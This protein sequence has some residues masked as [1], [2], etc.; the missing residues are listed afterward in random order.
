MTGALLHLVAN[1]GAAQN[2]WLDSDPQ[3]TFFKKIFRRHTPFATELVP[4]QFKTTLNFGGSTTTT[5]PFLGDLVYR[6]FFVC[7]IPKLAAMFINSKSQDMQQIINSTNFTDANF[8]KNLRKFAQGIDQVEFDRIFNLIDMTLENYGKE[9]LQCLNIINTM[10]TYKDPFG[11]TGI[12]DSMNNQNP[13]KSPLDTESYSGLT[14]NIINK[15]SSYDYTKFKMDL[16]DQ[17]MKYKKEYFLIYELLK[18]IYLSEKEIVENTPL[19]NPGRLVDDL[20]L[21]DIF[22]N[23]LPNKEIFFKYYMNNINSAYL[24]L[25]GFDPK[26]QDLNYLI[27]QNPIDVNASTN[28]YANILYDFGPDFHYMLNSYNIIINVLKSMAKTVPIVIAKAFFISE[29]GYNIYQNNNQTDI[30]SNF[31]FPTI[32]DPNYK[33][34]FMLNINTLEKPI[35]DNNFI[36]IDYISTFEQ[37]YPNKYT[38]AY[39]QLFNNQANI[40]F[41]NIRKFM[42][43]LFQ[44][45]QSKL[46]SST[47]KLFFNNSPPLSNIYG[48]IAPTNNFK[49]NESHRIKNVFNTN[50]WFFYFFKYLDYINEST[51]ATYVKNVVVPSISVNG[52]IFF[53]NM[54]LLLKINIEYYMN[55]I[56]YLLNDLYASSPSTNPNDSMKNYAPVVYHN[57]INNIDIHNNLLAITILFHRNHVPTILEMFQYIY[58]FLSIMDIFTI[59]TYLAVDMPEIEVAEIA[60]IRTIAKLLYYNIFKYFMDVYDRFS[61]EAPANFTMN[62]YDQNENESIKNY[63]MHF[64]NGSFILPSSYEQISLTKNVSQ[65]EF[66]F[67]SEMVN[68]REQQKFY[69]NTLFNKQYILE[70]VGQTSADLVGMIVNSFSD[71]DKN[72]VIDIGRIMDSADPV[73]NY[74]DIS[75]QHNIINGMPDKLYYATF[76]TKR[77]N[78]EAYINTPYVSRNYGLVPKP[79]NKLPLL[80]P[81]PLPPTDPYGIDP[82]YYEHNQAITDFISL[83]INN[84]NILQMNIPVYWITNNDNYT[85]N[86]QTNNKSFQMYN[87]DYFRIKHEIFYQNSMHIPITFIDEYQFHLLK[88]L[89]LTGHL[90]NIYPNYDKYLYHWIQT[91]IFYLIKHT[92]PAFDLSNML[93]LYLDYIEESIDKNHI[94]VPYDFIGQMY[95]I[96]EHMYIEF[97]KNSKIEILQQAKPFMTPNMVTNNKF[98]DNMLLNHQKFN[99]VEKVALLR[100]NFLAQ[101]F[102]YVKYQDS[103]N[104]INKI[105]CPQFITYDDNIAQYVY[106]ILVC[107]NRNGV[108]LS[109]LK[110]F[111]PIVYLYPDM[112]PD[113]ISAILDMLGKLDDFGQYIFGS[114]I[115]FFNPNSMAKLTIKDILDIINITFM[116]TK[117]IYDYSLMNNQLQ[118]IMEK[119]SKYQPLLLNKLSLSNEINTY[120]KNFSKNKYLN[121]DNIDY[122]SKLANN[123][124]INYNIYKNYLVEQIMPLYNNNQNGHNKILFYNLVDG[125]LDYF[126][127]YPNKNYPDKSLSVPTTFKKHIMDDMFDISHQIP[128]LE[129]YFKYIDNEYYAFIYFFMDYAKKNNLSSKDIKNPLIYICHNKKNMSG[130][131]SCEN[132]SDLLKYLMDHVWDCSITLCSVCDADH[133]CNHDIFGYTDRF[134]AIINKIHDSKKY[135]DQAID[136]TSDDHIQNIIHALNKANSITS[137]EAMLENIHINNMTNTNQNYYFDE[138][139]ERNSI[140]D[141]TKDIAKKGIVVLNQQKNEILQFK[142]RIYNILYRNKRA[143]A[144]WIRKLAHF[145]VKE[146][147]FKCGDDITDHHI[148]DWFESYHEVSKHNG[149]EPAY[150]KMIGHRKDLIIFDDKI[151]KSYTIIMPFIFYFNKHITFSLPLNSSI[152]TKYQLDIQ[153]RNLDEVTYKEEFSEFVNPNTNLNEPVAYVPN[154][155]NAQLMIEYI[156]LSTE[157]RKVFVTNRLEY[158]IDELQYDSNF[159]MNDN[160]LEPIYKIG[161]TKKIKTSIKNR[162]KIREEFYEIHKGIFIGQTELDTTKH[163]TDLLP[164]NDYVAEKYIDRTGITKMMMVYR[165]LPN[166]DPYVHKKRIEMKNYFNHPS[167]LMVVLFKIYA[168][169]NLSYRKN[170]NNYFNGEKQWDNYGLYSYYDLKNITTAKEVHYL[171]TKQK[172]NDIEDP[173]FGCLN[174]INQ[175]LLDYTTDNNIQPNSDRTNKWIKSNMSYFLEMLQTVKDKYIIY[176]DEIFYGENIV[177]LKENLSA[178]MINYHIIDKTI[179]YQLVDDTYRNLGLEPPDDDTINITF[180]NIVDNFDDG[181]LDITKDIFIEG[182]LELLS[183]ITK[184]AIKNLTEINDLIN[185]I[186]DGYNDSQTNFLIWH[187]NNTININNFP[188]DLKSLVNLYYYIYKAMPNMDKNIMSSTELIKNKIN[189]LTHDDIQKLNSDPIKNLTFKDIILQLNGIFKEN[190]FINV[191]LDL[192]PYDIVQIISHKMSQKIN[193]IIDNRPVDIINFQEHMISNYQI[194]PLITGYLKFNGYSIMPENSNSIMWSEAQAYQFLSHTPSTGINLYSWSL[195]PLS[196]QPQGAANLSK[197][198]NFSSVFDMHPL[199]GN[200]CPVQVVRMVLSINIMRYLS[201]MCGKAWALQS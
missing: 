120:I 135:I 191:Y 164:R 26:V 167:K 93:N 87:I 97:N 74:W 142:N 146:V 76:N 121:D 29:T 19:M 165:P 129:Q 110:N 35:E 60:K 50:I 81:I 172:I 23:L 41:N 134:T 86:T 16:A 106:Q 64:M 176:N 27:K 177:R 22:Q 175:I 7:D 98:I 145:L 78:G 199:I 116:M 103:I 136:Q 158:L 131:Q 8:M 201:G 57:K 43:L 113:Q 111:S 65:M 10:N 40:M 66:Y 58:H 4:V 61:F 28:T 63:V 72:F 127:L 109:L 30:S 48:Y 67:V 173:V 24:H 197:I 101:Y 102:Y 186:Y 56:S 82:L 140:I 190:D 156:Y 148:S 52:M 33:N 162:A 198:D 88:L 150:L 2:V 47:D 149:T 17:W 85:T 189:T 166:V 137:F 133:F 169:T 100:D 25:P 83:P 144:A 18:F 13:A 123:Y 69:H 3:I 180:K 84:D 115:S 38:N 161:S 11:T 155:S 168:H 14:K 15:K 194:N 44:S 71:I 20:L 170:E 147:T 159:N 5:I 51:F 45:Y 117:G 182:I 192:I 126:L 157:E 193:Q 200:D 12:T 139:S 143:K 154:I 49:D 160:N 122:I 55:E 99:I 96:L 171:T 178:L 112:F 1:S 118:Y 95:N 141:L 70:N 152:N 185:K 6:I 62:E 54:L 174:I 187:I 36:P 153:L 130:G 179:L 94:I 128:I 37:L 34:I 163:T 125:D 91:S 124:G 77:Y 42:E 73:R 59:N 92:D 108:D 104:G 151:K 196:I 138:L 132:V 32:I 181:D 184:S 183:P 39:L 188:Y 89:T 9:E 80:P 46:F 107:I 79:S 90:K 53:K 75:Y 105:L 195:D 119:L 21:V 68:M 31:Q 114:V